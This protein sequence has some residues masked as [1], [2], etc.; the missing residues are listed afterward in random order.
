MFGDPIYEGDSYYEIGKDIVL[1]ENLERWAEQFER[2]AEKDV[3]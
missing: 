1:K 2:E 3:V